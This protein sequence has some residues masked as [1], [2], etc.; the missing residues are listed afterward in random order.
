AGEKR[1][2]YELVFERKETVDRRF[3]NAD[4]VRTGEIERLLD[5]QDTLALSPSLFEK[6][7]IVLDSHL[8]RK[9]TLR[10]KVSAR[11]VEIS[12]PGFP[13]LG[14]WSPK[15]DVPF[16]C[17]EPWYGIM[18]LANSAQELEKKAGCLSVEPGKKFVAEYRI[19]VS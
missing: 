13:Q 17:I 6:G 19:A 16:V 9:L 14:I 2:D 4:N 12:F 1:E 3:L 18:P 10:S 7:A 8:S 5:G 15:G 11:Q